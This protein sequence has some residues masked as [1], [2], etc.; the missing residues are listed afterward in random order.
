MLWYVGYATI[1]TSYFLT[2][3]AKLFAGVVLGSSELSIGR[4]PLDDA[5]KDQL[6]PLRKGDVMI[7]FLILNHSKRDLAVRNFMKQVD[8]YFAKSTFAFTV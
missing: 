5:S 4:G 2:K 7:E 8:R 1:S 6:I 3:L